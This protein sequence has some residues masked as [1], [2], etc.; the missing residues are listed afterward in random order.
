[1]DAALQ[2]FGEKGY[3]GART[4][5]IARRAGVNQQLISYYFGGKQGLLEELRRRWAA[6]EAALVP[7]DATFAE[8]VSAYM[9]ATLDGPDW[10]RLVIWQALGDDP[11]DDE[12]RT[13]ARL[14]RLSA[15]VDRVR[16]R[17][18]EGEVTGDVE[19]EFVVLLAYVLVFAP[20][21][22][23]Q[24]V[25]A[26]FGVDPYGPEYRRRCLDQLLMLLD[27]NRRSASMPPGG[28][29]E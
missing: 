15:S 5:G 7:A 21:A 20:V 25:E 28:S 26:F 3:S 2:E 6:T 8:S 16:R 23:P 9:D 19:A 18:A 1:M 14:G 10:A 29:D 13:T 17:Q 12:Q 27:P 22:M 24:F 4:A 11:G